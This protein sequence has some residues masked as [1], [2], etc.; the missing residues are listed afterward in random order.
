M[1]NILLILAL[2]NI[3]VVSVCA[4]EGK[5]SLAVTSNYVVRGITQSNDKSAIQPAYQISQPDGLGFY[6]GIFAS[7]VTK[8]SEVDIYGGL[9]LGLGSDA[10]FILDI[11]AIEYLYTEPAFAPASHETYLGLQY[12]KSYIKYYFGEEKARYLDVGTGFTVS[13]DID[14]LL[15]FGE[16]FETN[17]NGND[18]SLTLQ[19][20]FE[21]IRLGLTATHEDKTVEKESKMFAYISTGF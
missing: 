1:K 12:D 6:A 13:G 18:V 15:H 5:L 20:D 7:N 2:L 17:E 9:A 4:V 16:V 21:A 3:P 14:L 11:G 10:A 19:K 8:G